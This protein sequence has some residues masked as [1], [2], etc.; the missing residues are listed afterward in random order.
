VLSESYSGG[1]LNGLAVTNAYD[2]FLRRTNLAL[3][4]QAA[5][6]TQFGYDTAGR[7]QSVT[8]GNYTA[9]SAIVIVMQPNGRM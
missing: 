2:R 7:L 4:T 6:L 1:A 5:T 8:N 9:T 3:N